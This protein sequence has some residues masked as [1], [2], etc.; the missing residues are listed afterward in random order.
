MTIKHTSVAS[1][2]TSRELTTTGVKRTRIISICLLIVVLVVIRAGKVHAQDEDDDYH[3][4]NPV[5]RDQMRDF[6]IDRPDVTESPNTVDA[7]HFQFEGDLIKWTRD[8]QLNESNRTI[9]VFS[10]LYK[11]GLLKS[12]DI[13]LGLEM[14]NLYQDFEGKTLAKGYGTT[15]IR[16]KHNFWGNNGETKTALG[17]IPYISFPSS[18]QGGEEVFGVGFPFSV[19]VTEK[20]GGGAQFQVDF[21]P[22][23]RGNHDPAILQTFVVGGA[24]VG[25][26]DFYAELAAY[27]L[28]DDENYFANGGLIYNL[29]K[30]LKVDVAT[31]L[32]LT[33]TASTR[34]YLG[35]SFRI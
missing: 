30:N 33:E 35:L 6:S 7:G 18:D 28:Q 29:G 3:L 15:T 12:W 24:I 21:L 16:L 9:S 27:F 4:F 14:F 10:G 25:D 22:D 19:G 11:M 31:N 13:H 8:S 1:F 23:G 34:V 32:G 2:V 26:L 5:P 17:I 20:L